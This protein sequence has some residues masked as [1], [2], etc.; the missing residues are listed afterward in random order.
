M[1]LDMYAFALDQQPASETDFELP[2]MSDEAWNKYFQSGHAWG[3]KER[4]DLKKRLE[5]AA[6][7]ET[8]AYWRKHPNLHGFI[9]AIYERRGGQDFQWGSFVGP[10]I[11][12]A[13]DIDAIETATKAGTLPSTDGFFFGVTTPEDHK[14]TLE[15]CERAR[16]MIKAGKTIAYWASW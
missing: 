9:G 12:D 2:E 11:L 5:R 15:F 8:V 13:D 3:S 14:D 10:V 16:G 7:Y 1:G 6:G 4:E